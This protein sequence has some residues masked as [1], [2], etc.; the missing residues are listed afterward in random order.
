MVVIATLYLQVAEIADD[1]KPQGS[2]LSIPRCDP[3]SNRYSRLGAALHKNLIGPW[4][5]STAA[6]ILCCIERPRVPMSGTV[7]QFA[8]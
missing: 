6:G 4:L 3:P 7:Q 8:A 2:H 5:S 1:V